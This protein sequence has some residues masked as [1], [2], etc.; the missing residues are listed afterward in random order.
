MSLLQQPHYDQW[1]QND[2]RD[3]PYPCLWHYDFYVPSLLPAIFAP[4]CTVSLM[5]E[6]KSV[7]REGRV[8]ADV[9]VFVLSDAWLPP[10][11]TSITPFSV[12][13]LRM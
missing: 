13:V 11:A 4:S 2:V 5:H 3:F 7:L 6:Q 12:T 10:R 1:D 9:D 8:V